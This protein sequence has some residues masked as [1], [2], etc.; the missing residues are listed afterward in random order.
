MTIRISNRGAK[1]IRRGHLWVYRSDIRDP[2]DTEAGAIVE[3]VDEAGNFI[4]QAFYS[5]ASEIALRFLTT[6]KEQIGRDWWRLRLRA[7]AARRATITPETN[8]YR[9]IYSEGDLLPSIII[10]TYDGH[11]VLQTL[12]QGSD[13]IQQELVEMLVEEFQPKSIFEL[14]DARVREFERLELRRGPV[15]GDALPEIEV[16]Q[17]G[18]RFVV[19]PAMGQKTGAFLDQRENYLAA[20]RVARG[21]ALDCFTFNGGFAL[22]IARNCEEVLGVDISEDA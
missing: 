19:S 1:R 8:A 15:Y 14:N 11:Y 5:D 2:G 3:V 18:V 9:L 20:Q 17:N 22:H 7:A 16:K 12:S 6:T 21:R 4:G 13:R 10:D